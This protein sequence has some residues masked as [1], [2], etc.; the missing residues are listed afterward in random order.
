M[1]DLRLQVAV[2]FAQHFGDEFSEEVLVARA[3]WLLTICVDGALDFRRR[4]ISR[5]SKVKESHKQ[6]GLC[7]EASLVVSIRQ[8]EEELV[9]D[10][11]VETLEEGV[12]CCWVRLLR[13]IVDEL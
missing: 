1:G 5:M 3:N 12:D 9:Q 7:L 6:H 11:D 4:S 10:S 2:G 13:D 8:Y